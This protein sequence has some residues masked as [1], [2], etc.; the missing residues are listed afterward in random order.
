MVPD[1]VVS[2]HYNFLKVPRDHVS[3]VQLI[4]QEQLLE[5]DTVEF[6]VGFGAVYIDGRRVR[7]DQA[8]RKD[9]ILRIHSRPRRFHIDVNWSALIHADEPEFLILRKPHGVPVH[10]TLDNSVENVLEQLQ[11]AT[12]R[13]LYVTQRLD[14][15]TG[16][17]LYLA[18]TPTN[19][20]FFNRQLA[21]RKVTKIYHALVAN[22]VSPQL[23]E[24]WMIKSLRQPRQVV[25]QP[26]TDALYCALTVEMSKTLPSDWTQLR[27]NLHTGRTHQI[28]VQLAALNAPLIGDSIY[29]SPYRPLR[30]DV[31]PLT[32]VALRFRDE[33]GNDHSFQID[34]PNASEVAIPYPSLG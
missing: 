5:L 15:S 33:D 32:S 25:P 16:G 2:A 31:L 28:R 10:A 27:L 21:D 30:P 12:G 3:L 13:R 8:V 14:I 9:Q 24:H 18:K 26:Q 29:G 7:T 22:S 11:N 20:T 4:H 1:L 17:L 19:Q 23:Y 6:L 34:P